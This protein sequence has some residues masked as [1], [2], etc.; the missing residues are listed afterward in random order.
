[1]SGKERMTVLLTGGAGVLGSALIE[2]LMP[3]YRLICLTH[4]T[5]IHV[6]G[7][8]QI[9]A[10][11][12]QPLLGLSQRGFD[13]L[14]GKIQWIIHSAAITRLTGKPKEIF[15]VNSTGTQNMLEVARHSRAPLYHIS[16]AFTHP[17]DYFPGVGEMTPCEMAKRQAEQKVRESG[18]C[19][20]IFRP[21]IL[22]GNA[23]GGHM[24]QIQGLH[25]TMALVME[26]GRAHV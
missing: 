17:C 26:I 8:E 25:A 23:R 3:D 9:Q 10:D 12:S 5:P 22:I 16:T 18:L 2:Q 4:K 19:T 1:M 21:S 7:V 15:T 24:P 6:S 11:I 14:C 20:S 13:E